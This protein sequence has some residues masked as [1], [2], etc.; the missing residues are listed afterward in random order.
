MTKT[1]LLLVAFAAGFAFSQP[2]AASKK[3]ADQVSQTVWSPKAT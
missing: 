2:P 3:K 1:L